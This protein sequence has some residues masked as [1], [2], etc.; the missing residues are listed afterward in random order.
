M[1]HYVGRMIIV[2][3]NQSELF[4]Q[5]LRELKIEKKLTLKEIGAIADVTE[6][7]VGLWVTG[8]RIPENQPLKKI[9]DFLEVS[10]DYLLGNSNIREKAENI[11]LEHI[12]VKYLPIIGTVRAGS[13]GIAMWQ[14]NPSVA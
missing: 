10:T 3:Q 4:G 11:E 5:R 14:T 2:S 9:A 6:G 12:K 7:A 1:L 13:G 8:K